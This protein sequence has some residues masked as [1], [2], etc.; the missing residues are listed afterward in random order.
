MMRKVQK[1]PLRFG[2]WAQL[3]NGFNQETLIQIGGGQYYNQ[4]NKCIG[5]SI[6]IGKWIE[7]SNQFLNFGIKSLTM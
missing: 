2:K 3:Y 6:K 1:I 5:E 4:N 7:L